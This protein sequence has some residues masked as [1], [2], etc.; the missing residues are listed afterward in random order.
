M[1]RQS[2][3]IF[4]FVLLV[5]L[6]LGAATQSSATERRK[7]QFQTESSY[8][9]L[10]LYVELP[11]IGKMVVVTGSAGNIAGTNV[12][13][14]V[15]GVTGDVQGLAA[16]I[17]DIHIIPQ[18]LILS[19]FNA[20]MNKVTQNSY[21]SRGM[22]SDPDN[23]TLVEASQFDYFEP[24][25]TLTLFDRRFEVF[26]AKGKHTVNITR[27]YD[28]EGN[29]INDFSPGYL[30]ESSTT[31]YGALLDLTDDRQDPRVGGRGA[32]TRR[33]TPT[34]NP[35][36]P[37]Y[38]V[39]DTSLTAYLPVGKLST[40]ALNYFQSEAQVAREGQTDRALLEQQLGI[41]CL[42]DPQCE[43]ARAALVEN[44]WAAN[45]YGTATSIG[46]I[47]RLR[48]YPEGRFQGAHV[49][50]LGAEFRWNLMEGFQPFDWFIWKDIRTGSQIAFFYET[51]TVADTKEK[52]GD[53]N[54][55]AM[56]IG[57]RLVTASGYVYRA[58]AA[59]GSEGATQI[60]TFQYPW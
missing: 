57:F 12:D 11:G 41:E 39:L 32:V 15:L 27:I 22:D 24:T 17:S 51:A 36:S 56:G 49:R 19:V 58:E 28:P 23:Y 10:P 2:R 60:V 25:I 46:G 44:Y 21:G 20:E 59:T 47:N 34:E 9:L 54:K 52:L 50:Y 14:Y 48:A 33:H 4:T 35:D 31:T 18:T 40:I 26:G 29:L 45:K 43:A 7:P 55:S 37:D 5:N 1:L 30:T 8:L 42:G 53:I 6:M 16:E 38:Q 13:A 3:L